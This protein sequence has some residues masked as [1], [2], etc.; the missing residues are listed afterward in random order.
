[1]GLVS[2]LDT[3]AYNLITEFN[4]VHA[5]GF[6]LNGQ[7]GTNFFVQPAG[8]TGSAGSFNVNITDPSL[9]AASSDTAAGGN[10]NLLSLI[11]LQKQQIVQGSPPMTF[12][13]NLLYQVG[14]EISN[15]EAEQQASDLISQQLADQRGAVSGV[16]L[17]DEA[18]NL[19]RYQ[20]AFE[21]A[22]RVVDII[23]SLTETA[24]NLGR[25]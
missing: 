24:V 20:R 22:A 5:N 8:Q 13:G 17:N 11:D 25:T 12:Y 23:S 7:P 4:L 9:V 15:A 10:A 19:L 14:S 1:P 16:S 2:D 6:D 3:L 21:A 18:T